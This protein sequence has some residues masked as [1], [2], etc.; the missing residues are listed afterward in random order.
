LSA[1]VVPLPVFISAHDVQ[2]ALGCSRRTAYRILA[3]IA[4]ER[5]RKGTLLRVS[6]A[7]WEEYVKEVLCPETRS[8]GLCGAVLQLYPKG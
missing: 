1:R 7:A 4:G 6:L 2:T 3:A 5:P 8:T